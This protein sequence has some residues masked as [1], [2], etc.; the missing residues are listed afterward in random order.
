MGEAASVVLSSRVPI[1][2]EAPRVREVWERCLLLKA[3][4]NEWPT[5]TV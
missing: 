2:E 3:R 5:S 1:N 4:E